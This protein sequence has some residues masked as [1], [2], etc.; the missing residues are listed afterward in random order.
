MRLADNLDRHKISNKFKF[1][2]DQ[3]CDFGVSGPLVSKKTTV[4][5]VQSIACLV[6]TE[7]L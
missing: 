2:P 5:V 1:R 7:T 6:L 4:E 3:M